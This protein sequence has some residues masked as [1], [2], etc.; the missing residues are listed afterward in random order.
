MVL[1][2]V[3]L[4]MLSTKQPESNHEYHRNRLSLSWLWNGWG[5]HWCNGIGDMHDGKVM[6]PLQVM[7]MLHYNG[8][9]E[10]YAKNEPAHATSPAVTSQRYELCHEGLLAQ[11]VHS[12]SGWKT[13][14]RGRAYVEH[15]CA[16]QTPV[17]MWVQPSEG[18]P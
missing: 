9:A 6:T 12:G 11:D 1:G 4:L 8:I 18:K 10:P 14:D 17:C 2:S 15:V 13:T 5:F 16:V 3:K 7:M